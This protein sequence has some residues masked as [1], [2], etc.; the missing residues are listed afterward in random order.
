MEHNFRQFLSKKP[1]IE[2]CYQ[3]GLINRRS[4]A[5]Y[6]IKHNIAKSH[7]LGA[8]IAMLRRFTFKD[9]RKE[10]EDLLK[11]VKINIKDKISILDFE[12]IFIIILSAIP[13]F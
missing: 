8:V 12:K 9:A 7:R 3:E 10:T 13:F 4:L 6:L 5:R 1:E 2:T 11:D